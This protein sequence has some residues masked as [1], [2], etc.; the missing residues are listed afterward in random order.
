[1]KEN[2][3]GCFFSEHNVEVQHVLSS[4]ALRHLL[5]KTIKMQ[6]VFT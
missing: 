5:L 2:V 4:R 6:S 1:M 3:S